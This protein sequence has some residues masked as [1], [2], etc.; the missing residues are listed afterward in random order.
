[1]QGQLRQLDVSSSNVFWGVDSEDLIYFGDG[2]TR[3]LVSG[4]LTHVSIGG[5]G[6]WGVNVHN[7][8]FFR[9]GVTESI[10]QG[11]DWLFID[12]ETISTQY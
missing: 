9:R 1:V 2:T 8:T 12:G 7:Q 10:P 11:T 4:R 6:I 3:Q 5:S